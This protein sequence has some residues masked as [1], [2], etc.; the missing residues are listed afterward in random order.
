M[1]D[2]VKYQLERAE[3]ALRTALQ[4]GAATEDPYLLRNIAETINTVKAWGASYR[5]NVTK[6]TTGDS[7]KFN[8]TSSMDEMSSR[9]Y[10]VDD[11]I[12]FGSAAGT[13]ATGGDTV[14]SF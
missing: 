4:L 11:T 5:Y 10:G 8:F 14:L 9:Y 1:I 2:T 6:E 7:I 3:E 12:S 13:V